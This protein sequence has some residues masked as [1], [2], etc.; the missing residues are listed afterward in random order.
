MSVMRQ[1]EDLFANRLRTSF[2]NY[3]QPRW[4]LLPHACLLLLLALPAGAS[5]EQALTPYWAEYKVSISVLGGRLTTELRATD[6]GYEAN[7]VI[8]PTGLA[9]MFKNGV[10]SETSHFDATEKGIQASWYRSED[11]LSKK[12]TRAEVTF[13]WPGNEISG[14][15]NDEEVQFLLEG[16]VHDRVAIQYQ[17]MHD[18]LN[19]DP[20]ERYILYDIDEFKTLVVSTIGERE[21]KTRAGTYNAVGIQHQAENSSRV[22]TLW[23]VPELGFTPAVIEQHRDGKLRLRATLRSY[24][25]LAE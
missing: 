12:K 22:T 11:S 3:L 18:L 16:L 5:E 25:P 4:N 9:R 24:S 1:C 14:T 6:E 17:L 13:D 7:H 20:D 2:L 15:I 10:I 23:C 21:V 19:G 8:K